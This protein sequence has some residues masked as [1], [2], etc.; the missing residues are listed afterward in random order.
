M[1]VRGCGWCR[2]RG[3]GLQNNGRMRRPTPLSADL[4]RDGFTVQTAADRG[5]QRGRLRAADLTAPFHGVRRVGE[6]TTIEEL[7]RSYAARMPP[8]GRF[9]HTTS[10]QLLGLRMPEAFREHALHVGVPRPARAPR[11]RGVIGHQVDAGSPTLGMGG[12]PLTPAF[13]TWLQ[14]A[15]LLSADDLIIMGDGLLRRFKPWASMAG[16]AEAVSQAAGCRGAAILREAL[17]SIRPGTDS[18]R[19]TMLR[20]IVVRA[21]FPEPEVNGPIVNRYGATI[22]H[23]DLVFREKKVILEYEGRH[24]A[25]DERQFSIDIARLDELMEE[26]WRVIRVDKRLMAARATLFG[27]IETALAR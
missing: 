26:G 8:G 23:G 14:C 9:T 7:A 15:T 19:E 13:E 3:P 11:G 17:A 10:A 21:G 16:L 18:A 24:H 4:D 12:L 5:L 1:T 20:L 27:K 2:A 6:P 22:A 25:D